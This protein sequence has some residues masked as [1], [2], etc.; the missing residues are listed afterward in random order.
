ML[1]FD[2]NLWALPFA[3]DL[4]DPRKFLPAGVSFTHGNTMAIFQLAIGKNYW[5][6][7][8]GKLT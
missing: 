7:P 8:D 5:K 2:S 4:E 6:V 3:N 1:S